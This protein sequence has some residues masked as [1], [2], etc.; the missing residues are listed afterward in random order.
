MKKLINFG[1]LSV[2]TD[3]WNSIYIMHVVLN[4]VLMFVWLKFKLMLEYACV[5]AQIKYTSFKQKK[6]RKNG[7]ELISKYISDCLLSYPLLPFWLK[8]F[9]NTIQKWNWKTV[10]NILPLNIANLLTNRLTLYQQILSQFTLI[11]NVP[12]TSSASLLQWR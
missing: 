9:L 8:I 7:F 2:L 11:S 12:T 4:W 6:N 5:N 1:R 3:R 10:C